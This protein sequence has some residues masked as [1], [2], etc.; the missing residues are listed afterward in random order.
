MYVCMYVC[1]CVYIYI[2][3]CMHVCVYMYICMYIYIYVSSDVTRFRSCPVGKTYA[4]AHDTFS[5]FQI[6]RTL[7]QVPVRFEFDDGKVCVCVCVCVCV[8]RV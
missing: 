3:V 1:V 7:S 6:F 8:V 2:Y 5:E 4:H